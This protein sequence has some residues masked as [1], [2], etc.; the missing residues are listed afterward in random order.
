MSEIL[1]QPLGNPIAAGL[2]LDQVADIDPRLT[3]SHYFDGRLL[4]AED[5]TR[6]QV[7]LDQRLRELGRVLGSGIVAGLALSFDRFTG[8]LTLEP[9]L[10]MTPAGRVLEL[11]SRLIVNLRDRALISGLNDGNFSNLNRGLYAVVLRYVDVGTDIAEVF[12]K[13]LSAKR[14]FQFAMITES[15]QMGLVPL[16]IPLP[17]QSPLQIRA[18]LMRELLG[19]DQLHGLLPED[20]VALGLVAIQEG[21]PQWLDAQLLRHPL[22]AEPGIDSLQS[23]LSRQYESLLADILSNRRSGGLTGDFHASDYFSLLPPVGSLPKEAVDPVNGRQGY[24][25]ENYQVAIAPLRQSDVEQIRAESLA[26]PPIDL[27]NGEPVDIVVL[28]PLSNLDYGHYAAQ[29]E[30]NF[31]PNKR[32]LPQL[33]LLRLK[34]YPVRPVHALDTDQAAWQAIWDRFGSNAPLYVR[35]PSRAAETSISGIVLA[36]GTS[37]P[38]PPEVVGGPADGGGLIDDE[39]NVFLKRVNYPMLA[40][41]RAPTDDAGRAALAALLESFSESV[42]VAASQRIL[43]LVERQYDRVIWQTLQQLAAANNLDAFL[44]ALRVKPANQTTR[45]LVIAGGAA[46]GLDSGLIGQWTALLP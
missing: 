9:G 4:T 33:D 34:L 2:A 46:L 3:R 5:L 44:A 6:D 35:R 40:E 1:F 18:R 41:L 15:V 32:L 7:Y 19:D 24:F 39:D 13:D 17:Q 16:P 23:D 31:D 25:P 45:E 30:R 21:A 8:L 12:P 27:S 37:L 14:G 10:A 43:L 11:G 29:L 22:R 28:V 20:A 36:L 38:A 26:L 42:S